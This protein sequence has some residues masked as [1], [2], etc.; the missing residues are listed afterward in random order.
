MSGTDQNAFQLML[1]RRSIRRFKQ[2]SLS[3]DILTR[4][5]NV[6]HWAPSGA[7]LQPLEFLVVT[8]ADVCEVVFSS[9]AWAAYISPAGTPPQGQRPVAY[10]VVLVNTSVRKDN[11][12][13][14][15]GAAMQ[16]MIL[17]AWESGIGA[18][19]IGSINKAQLSEALKVPSG[20]VI[21]AVL[22][23]GYPAEQPVVEAFDKDCKYW[24]DPQGVLHV[25]KRALDQV[26]HINRFGISGG[27]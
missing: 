17:A 24:K 1:T 21:E 10:V 26:M 27:L 22:A 2:D 13:Y 5:V 12:Q 14:D 15:V 11:Y 19:W 9:L 18:C 8:S 6:A 20:Y 25:P 16:S 4:M 3:P 23:A 7:N